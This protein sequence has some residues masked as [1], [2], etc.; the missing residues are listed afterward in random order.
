MTDFREV[1]RP[2]TLIIHESKSSSMLSSLYDEY[3][4]RQVQLKGIIN[5]LVLLLVVNNVRNVLKS[6]KTHGF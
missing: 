4:S 3:D 6:L 2:L 1:G 5:L